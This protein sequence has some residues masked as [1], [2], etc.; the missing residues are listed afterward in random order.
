[1]V[2]ES[3]PQ[4]ATQVFVINYEANMGFYSVNKLGA[5]PINWLQKVSITT[6][7]RGC[8]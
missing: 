5:I 7:V 8:F 3:V 4:L 2:A 1:M 6:S